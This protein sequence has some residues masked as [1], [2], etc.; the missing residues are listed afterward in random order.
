MNIF[1]KLK[2]IKKNCI[3]IFGVVFFYVSWYFYYFN[4]PCFPFEKY[5]KQN[6]K[7]N[8]MKF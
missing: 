7:K 4:Y 8:I 5:N 3:I 1:S 2:N 6:I